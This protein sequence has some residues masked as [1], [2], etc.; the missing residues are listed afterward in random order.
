MAEPPPWADGLPDDALREIVRRVPCA[1]DRGSMAG[2]CREWR[3]RLARLP[4]PPPQFPWLIVSS[5]DSTR[6]YCVLSGGCVH[7]YRT[8]APPHGARFFGSCEG[9]WLFLAFDQTSDNELV[10]LRHDRTLLA[11]DTFRLGEDDPFADGHDMAILAAALSSPPDK[12]NCVGACII[13]RWPAAPAPR[14]FAFW[15]VAFEGVAYDVMPDPD[16]SPPQLEVEDVLCRN[17]VFYFL[18]Q[19]E[20]IRVCKPVPDEAA[21]PLQVVSDVRYFQPEGRNYQDPVRARYLL[22]SRDELLM[23]VRFASDPDSPTSGFMVFRVN[24]PREQEGDQVEVEYPWS[25]DELESLGGRML[26]VGRGCSRSYEVVQYPGFKDGIYFLDDR[27]FYDKEMMFHR[28]DERR[29]PCNDNGMWSQGPAPNVELFFPEQGPSDRSPPA[30][31]VLSQW[32]AKHL[33]LDLVLRI[34]RQ[35]ICDTDR[36]RALRAWCLKLSD[37]E[38]GARAIQPQLPWFLKPSSRGTAIWCLTCGNHSMSAKHSTGAP[39]DVRHARFYGSF[40]CRWLFFVLKTGQHMMGNLLTGERH[41]LPDQITFHQ[42]GSY[43]QSI[44]AASGLEFEQ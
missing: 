42:G 1:I 9:A 22:E 38:L 31:L 20:H 5:D 29:Y 35:V 6:A 41:H 7:H 12:K 23:V 30:W 2:V 37:S 14:R 24:G 8:N 39:L 21:G 16:P 19:G 28:A 15:N 36:V 17:G 11:P 44:L 26:F 27:C 32:H 34:I 25:W 40:D 4:R 3:T 33:P 18:T 10:N 43:P 13:S